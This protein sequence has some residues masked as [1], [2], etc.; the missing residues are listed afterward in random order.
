[1]LKVFNQDSQIKN[2]FFSLCLIVGFILAA[3]LF[4]GLHNQLNYNFIGHEN[5]LSHNYGKPFVSRAFTSWIGQYINIKTDYTAEEIV[6]FLEFIGYFSIFLSYFQYSKLYGTK[7]F[8]L[9]S[10]VFLMLLIPWFS[11]LPRYMPLYF[12][13]DTYSILFCILLLY[14]MQTRS[15]IFFAILLTVATL[16]RETSIIFIVCYFLVHWKF[17]S[18]WKLFLKIGFLL[19][20]WGGIKVF[21]NLFF[22]EKI[23]DVYQDQYWSNFKFLTSTMYEI[24]NPSFFELYYR[25]AYLMFPILLVSP[26]FFKRNISILPLRIRKTLPVGWLLLVIYFYTANIYEYRIFTEFLPL[27]SLPLMIVLKKRLILNSREK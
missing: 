17:A 26:L 16:N 19:V 20:L 6:Y 14:S 4:T 24:Q 13:Y 12:L 21:L 22:A 7:E 2:W 27:Y 18:K 25:T 9:A 10:T 3:L 11:F 5:Y 23:G 15:Y 8:A 1:M